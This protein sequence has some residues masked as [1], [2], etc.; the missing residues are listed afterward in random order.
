VRER[1]REKRMLSKGSIEIYVVR[2]SRFQRLKERQKLDQFAVALEKVFMPMLKNVSRKS[3]GS[4]IE[5]ARSRERQ[6]E[7]VK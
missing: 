2:E 1:E 4:L 7:I 3:E 5:I 6:I